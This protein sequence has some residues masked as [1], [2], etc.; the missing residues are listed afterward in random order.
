M[1]DKLFLSA[2]V[3]G[4][5]MLA[6]PARTQV[7]S[8]SWLLDGSSTTTN[9]LRTGYGF[10]HF[11]VAEAY[12]HPSSRLGYGGIL[13]LSMTDFND[14]GVDF[15]LAPGLRYYFAAEKKTIPLA[16]VNA[17]FLTVGDPISYFG[18]LGAGLN[19]FFKP[20]LAV[21]GLL[22]YTVS[23]QT[24]ATHNFGLEA[25]LR[26]WISPKGEEEQTF[27][28][29][30]RKGSWVL[31]SSFTVPV[32]NALSIIL[33]PQDNEGAMTVAPQLGYFIGRRWMLGTD[34]FL[35]LNF[36]EGY[37]NHLL[38]AIPYVRY[39]LSRP[40]H[41]WQWFGEGGVEFQRTIVRFEERS[42]FERRAFNSFDFAV[43][44]GTNF[45]LNSI[46]ALEGTLSY[47][48]GAGELGLDAGFRV[49][50]GK[51]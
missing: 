43:S 46:F 34:L 48:P 42:G 14:F 4:L 16:I 30:I 41:R 21:E 2:V 45:F 12:Y 10:Q 25:T 15:G 8:G 33:R 26:T 3:F 39:Y 40:E 5:L 27:T 49:F 6:S 38:Q 47:R 23:G 11:T 31:G 37:R 35:V 32:V 22:S 29:P 19:H 50:L 17:G 7:P 44:A 36:E 28:A 1:K 13:F 18:R 51:E 24:R 20:N 9:Y